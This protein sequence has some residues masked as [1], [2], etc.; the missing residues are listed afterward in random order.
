[1]KI[2]EILWQHRNDFTAVIECEH[3]GSCQ[4]LNNGYNDNFYHTK[5]L[6]SIPCKKCTKAT[7]EDRPIGVSPVS[8]DQ[9]KFLEQTEV[10]TK[11]WTEY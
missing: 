9:E 2:K 8:V 5:V 6:P 10:S 1:M 3:C 4:S 7:L 11:V